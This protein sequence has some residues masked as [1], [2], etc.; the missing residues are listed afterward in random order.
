MAT[1]TCPG[2]KGEGFVLDSKGKYVL[3]NGEPLLCACTPVAD[4]EVTPQVQERVRSNVMTAITLD[5]A[6]RPT[7]DRVRRP[8][9]TLALFV[10]VACSLLLGTAWGIVKLIRVLS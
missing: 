3:V 2:C 5:A 7:P 10:L 1:E 4:Y 6:Q 9:L 8:G